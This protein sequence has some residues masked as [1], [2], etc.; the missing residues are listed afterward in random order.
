MDVIFRGLKK[1]M[2]EF[3]KEWKVLGN[4][5]INRIEIFLLLL[6]KVRGE[7]YDGKVDI[8]VREGRLKFVWGPDLYC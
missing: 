6:R 1:L 8:R 2:G 3:K 7:I 4:G 5:V